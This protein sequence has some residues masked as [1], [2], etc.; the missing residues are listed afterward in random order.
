MKKQLEHAASNRCY[1]QHDNTL[2][3]NQGTNILE[4][5]QPTIVVVDNTLSINQSPRYMNTHTTNNR[6]YTK[7]PMPLT[8]ATSPGR[9]HD[10]SM[11]SCPRGFLNNLRMNCCSFASAGMTCSNEYRRPPAGLGALAA[12][13]I[14]S[15]FSTA[16][17]ALALSLAV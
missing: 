6:Y 15:S 13:P 14:P 8:N 1:R 17:L 12:A 9:F 3:I 7:H 5:T 4:H 2:N 10:C 11:R 16:L